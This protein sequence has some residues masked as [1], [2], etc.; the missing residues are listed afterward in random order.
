MDTG[1]LMQKHWKLWHMQYQNHLFFV[2]SL[3]G[4][5]NR[6]TLSVS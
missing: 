4:P 1:V 3:R 2:T 6:M 5:N